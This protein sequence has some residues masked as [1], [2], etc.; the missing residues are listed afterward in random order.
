MIK[1]IAFDLWETLITDTPELA[2][3]QEELRIALLS[4]SLS[5]AGFGDAAA[6]LDHAHRNVWDH[7]YELYWSGD[8]DIS[9]RTQV[10]HLLEL[11][12][13]DRAA[14]SERLLL[15]LEN[16]YGRPALEVLPEVV[17]HADEV[18]RHARDRGFR[19]GLISNTGRTPGSVLREVLAS[20]G[21]APLIDAMVFSNEHGEC[22]PRRSIFD[23]LCTALG[24]QHREVIFVGDNLYVDVYGA[25]Q[26][27]M[28]AVHFVPERR[29]LAVAS[30]PRSTW[31]TEEIVPDATITRLSELPQV[32]AALAA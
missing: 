22:K 9:T 30:P 12:G 24:V 32:L 4:K 23:R 7:C 17:P 31:P 16:A 26:C 20:H 21:L 18:L 3:R 27:G 19:I 1:A 25:Q 5:A 6:R 2:R 28:T 13:L 15:E 11:L 10:L 29:G 8:I 14:I